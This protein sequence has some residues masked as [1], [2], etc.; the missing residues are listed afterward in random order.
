[1]SLILCPQPVAIGRRRFGHRFLSQLFIPKVDATGQHLL[2]PGTNSATSFCFTK[3]YLLK[4][5][6][7]QLS[8]Q[9]VESVDPQFLDSSSTEQVP[10]CTEGGE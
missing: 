1:M 9:S 3:Y 10:V 5:N 4:V 8:K 6:P 2:E 7:H